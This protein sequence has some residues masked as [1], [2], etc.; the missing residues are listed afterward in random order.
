MFNNTVIHQRV[1]LNVGTKANAG[2]TVTQITIVIT[3]NINSRYFTKGYNSVTRQ[4]SSG[5]ST[6]TIIVRFVIDYRT[7]SRFRGCFLSSLL[8]CCLSLMCGVIICRFSLYYS[9]CWFRCCCWNNRLVLTYSWIIVRRRDDSDISTI[10]VGFLFTKA[11]ITYIVTL[12]T[13]TVSQTIK[14]KYIV[15]FNP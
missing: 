13:E 10:S 9:C 4:N 5:S 2:R 14:I 15:K 8:S 11:Y 12:T 7:V 6:S 3:P 1:Y